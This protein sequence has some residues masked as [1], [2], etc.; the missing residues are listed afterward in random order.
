MTQLRNAWDKV[1]D[2]Q[3]GDIVRLPDGRSLAVRACERKLP[4]IVSDLRGWVLVGELGPQAS[5][6]S[7]P[8]TPSDQVRLFMALEDVPARLGQTRKQVEGKV[9]YWAPHLPGVSG[10]MGQLAYAIHSIRGTD[11]VMILVW[12]GEELIVFVESGDCD[13]E[14]LLFTFLPR[15]VNRTERDVA[16]YGARVLNPGHAGSPAHQQKPARK[17]LRI[18]LPGR[19]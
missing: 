14:T 15:D 8:A 5:I 3:L 4:H 6:L 19:R 2:L 18:P 1:N 16:R 7:I 13:P 11:E 10:A 17:P 9:S 12:R